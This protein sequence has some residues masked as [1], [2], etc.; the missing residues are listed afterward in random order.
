MESDLRNIRD[1]IEKGKWRVSTRHKAWENLDGY[2]WLGILEGVDEN[3][4]GS[5]NNLRWDV[6]INVAWMRVA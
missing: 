3:S 6:V 5:Y 1:M 4:I 2:D